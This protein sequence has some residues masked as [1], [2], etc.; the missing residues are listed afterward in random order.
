MQSYLYGTINQKAHYGTDDP[1]INLYADAAFA[2]H[3]SDSKSHGGIYVT[4]GK[5]T[6]PIYVRSSKIKAVCTS[7]CEAELWKLVEGVQRTY[8]LAKLLEEIGVIES[9]QIT[10]H[11]DNMAA[12]IIS[13]AGEGRTTKSKHFRVR[14]D[15]L[16]QML[17]DGTIILKHCASPDMVPDYLTKGM[18]GEKY[19]RLTTKSLGLNRKGSVT[20]GTTA[21]QKAVVKIAKT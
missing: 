16:K 21:A 13:Y 7:I 20:P 12:I 1:T 18:V 17:E 19:I 2:V 11:E 4:L 6:G 5:D 15:F 14:F 10:V 8:P 9:L 3:P